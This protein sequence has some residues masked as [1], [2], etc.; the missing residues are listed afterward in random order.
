VD[1]DA[2]VAAAA[3]SAEEERHTFPA[4]TAGAL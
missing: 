1:V 3:A 4:V 2:L